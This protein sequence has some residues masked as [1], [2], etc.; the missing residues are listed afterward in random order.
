M[1][2]TVK[3]GTLHGVVEWLRMASMKYQ[4]IVRFLSAECWIM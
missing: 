2:V 4:R 1:E 3:K